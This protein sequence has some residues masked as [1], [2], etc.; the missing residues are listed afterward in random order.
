MVFD[1]GAN[2]G[3]LTAVF[4]KLGMQVIACEPDPVNY[5]ILKARFLKDSTITILD[6]AVADH[7][8]TVDLFPMAAHGRSLTTIS[9]KRRMQIAGRAE[10]EGGGIFEP[11]VKAKTITLAALIERYGVPE[12]IK[13]DVEGMEWPA[14]SS[15]TK[16][17]PLLSFEANLPE[18][19]A[20]TLQCLAYLHQLNPQIVFNCSPDDTLLILPEYL[21]YEQFLSW[22][23]I[24][25]Y[26]YLE[27]FCRNDFR[28][29]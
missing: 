22:L 4:L 24:Q 8:G 1:I 10:I 13:I 17:V 18:F 20:E 5:K 29:L 2:V 16:A 26:P 23:N 14:V 28:Q 21:P 11:T 12:F 27:I 25:Q 19:Q 9:E 3:D 7:V 6:V 15:L